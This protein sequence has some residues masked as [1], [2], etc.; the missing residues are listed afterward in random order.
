MYF[1]HQIQFLAR[2]SLIYRV[3]LKSVGTSSMQ[4]VSYTHLDVYKRQGY[5]QIRVETQSFGNSI[6]LF[7][8]TPTLTLQ[9]NYKSFALYNTFPMRFLYLPVFI[10]RPLTLVSDKILKS[11]YFYRVKY[12]LLQRSTRS[13]QVCLLYTSRCV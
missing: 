12:I 13:S 2:F 6:R 11:L 8:Q 3:A 1:V 4:T 5:V 7:Y 10:T 9:S